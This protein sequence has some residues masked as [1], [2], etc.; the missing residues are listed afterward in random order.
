M[1]IAKIEATEFGRQRGGARVLVL[2]RPCLLQFFIGITSLSKML[3]WALPPLPGGCIFYKVLGALSV[4][5]N[6]ERLYRALG[7][8]QEETKP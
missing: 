4:S 3:S 1:I 7:G 5:G 8:R 2:R 6:C